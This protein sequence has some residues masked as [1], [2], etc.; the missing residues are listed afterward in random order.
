M[1]ETKKIETK[2]TNE[3]PVSTTRFNAPVKRNIVYSALDMSTGVDPKKQKL[4]SSSV[5]L[6]PVLLNGADS[7]GQIQLT[8]WVRLIC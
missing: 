3:K 6:L 1:H 8:R 2:S 7:Y 4:V 5:L